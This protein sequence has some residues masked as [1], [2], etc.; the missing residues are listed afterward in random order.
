MGVMQLPDGIFKTVLDA[1]AMV[2]VTDRQGSIQFANE[3]F[4]AMSGYSLEELQGKN[5]RVLNSGIHSRAF[6]Q[7]LWATILRGEVW[8]GDICNKRRDGS[9]YW[10]DTAIFPILDADGAPSHFVV[11]RHDITDQNR[12]AALHRTILGTRSH[13]II[14]TDEAGVITV[15]NRGAEVMLGYTAEEVVGRASCILFHDP[16]ELVRRAEMLGKELSRPVRPDFDALIAKVDA[17]GNPDENDWTFIGKGG[18]RKMVR[19]SMAKLG[20]EQGEG[21]FGY[22]GIALD[23]S[24]PRKIASQVP[25]VVFQYLMRTDGSTCF[26]YASEGVTTILRLKPQELWLNADRFYNLIHPEDLQKFAAT[27]RESSRELKQMHLEF[28]VRFGEEIRWLLSNAVPEL[29][30]DGST[31]WHGFIADITTQKNVEE[32]VRWSAFHDPLTGL[33]NR[34][35]AQNEIIRMEYSRRYPIAVFNIDLDGL[36]LVNDRLGHEAGDEYIQKAADVLR[37]TFRTEDVVARM[38][39]DEFLILVMQTG[40]AGMSSIQSRLQEQLGLVN[41]EGGLAVSFSV[42][43]VVA[44]VIGDLE[45]AIREADRLMYIDKAARKARRQE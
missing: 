44:H 8:R 28:R 7:S 18:L 19:L 21:L 38:G 24:L 27:M 5:P 39:G 43:A 40:N 14:A 42:G 6:F 9:L 20:G 22:V 16:E 4:C 30:A 17:T 3:R 45:T 12:L 13:S 15:F 34:L 23:V 31:L 36:K 32:Q 11:V 35:Y 41:A 37:R 10:L 25:G 29:L 33:H 2:V 26:P 1:I